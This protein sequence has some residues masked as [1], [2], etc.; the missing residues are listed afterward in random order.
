MESKEEMRRKGSKGREGSGMVSNE[1]ERVSKG[2]EW[3]ELVSKGGEG[4]G[5]GESLRRERLARA[6]VLAPSHQEGSIAAREVA[7]VMLSAS[8]PPS[9]PPL[10]P[11][12]RGV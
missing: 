8:P 6:F 12:M 11:E 4:K 1:G 9:S 2:E 5:A 7:E 10:P 3:R